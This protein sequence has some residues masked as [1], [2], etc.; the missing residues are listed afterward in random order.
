MEFLPYEAFEGE[1]ASVASGSDEEIIAGVKAIIN[2]EGPVLGSRLFVAY[3]RASNQKLGRRI[4]E[5]LMLAVEQ[6]LN[7]GDIVADISFTRVNTEAMVLRPRDKAEVVV[8]SLGPRTL[9][10]VPLA[11]LQTVMC[12]LKQKTRT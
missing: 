5:R 2:V 4:R 7:S 9:E 8:R 6:A 11:E 10:Q 1:V 3:C 12:A